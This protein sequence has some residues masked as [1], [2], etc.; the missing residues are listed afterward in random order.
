MKNL[1]MPDERKG[2]GTVFNDSPDPRH[3]CTKEYRT[4]FKQALKGAIR[5][6]D[7]RATTMSPLQNIQ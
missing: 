5:K 4:A 2:K 7:H 6:D 1:A 3:Y